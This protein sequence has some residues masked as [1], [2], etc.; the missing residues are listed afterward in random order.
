MKKKSLKYL[1]IS[2]IGTAL[3]GCLT[4]CGENRTPDLSTLS[5]PENVEFSIAYEDGETKWQ[6]SWDRVKEA[7]GY[8]IT[9]VETEET[10]S[11]DERFDFYEL[12]SEIKKAGV[13]NLSIQAIKDGKNVEK[14]EKVEIE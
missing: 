14:S 5:A 7:D 1:I 10:Y 6:L 9:V 3:L 13:Y 12:S 2:C 8:E 11:V 4:A